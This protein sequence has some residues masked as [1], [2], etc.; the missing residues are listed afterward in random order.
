MNRS[1]SSRSNLLQRYIRSE[2]SYKSIMEAGASFWEEER[3]EAFKTLYHS[4]RFIDDQIDDLKARKQGILK[5]EKQELTVLVN[6]WV[7]T[8]TNPK[9]KNRVENQLSKIIRKFQIPREYV[10]RFAKAMILLR[11]NPRGSIL[12]Y[13]E[14][15]SED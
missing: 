8:L 3:Y 14:I 2:I 10:Q 11:H 4:F 9:V 7:N 15:E 6:H 1:E 5:T 12:P 13:E